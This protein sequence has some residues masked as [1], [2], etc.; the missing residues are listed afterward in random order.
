MSTELFWAL[1][2][3]GS[4][5]LPVPGVFRPTTAVFFWKE[6]GESERRLHLTISLSKT[7]CHS[8][9]GPKTPTFLR[10]GLNKKKTKCGKMLNRTCLYPALPLVQL[11]HSPVAEGQDACRGEPWEILK[12]MKQD[13]WN[14]LFRSWSW[15]CSLLFPAG[16]RFVQAG[17]F[18]SLSASLKIVWL[19]H[20]QI[21]LW[22]CFCNHSALDG[23]WGSSGLASVKVGEKI[24]VCD[25]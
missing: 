24:S 10:I 23:H 5:L 20:K 13:S 16:F 4:V 2:G 14:T 11:P 7:Q 15:H 12:V 19:V 3:C 8:E 18:S 25:C 1:P 6:G 9:Q 22:C 21:S 17:F